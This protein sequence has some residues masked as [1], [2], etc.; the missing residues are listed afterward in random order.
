MTPRIYQS[1]M[2]IE[3]SDTETLPRFSLTDMDEFVSRS[4]ASS[5]PTEDDCLFKKNH[6]LVEK[7]TQCS[8]R[9]SPQLTDEAIIE[10]RCDIEKALHM[11]IWYKVSFVVIYNPPILLHN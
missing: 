5:T 9:W 3:D 10:R 1:N 8:V 2:D 4:A 11:K 6:H 7:K